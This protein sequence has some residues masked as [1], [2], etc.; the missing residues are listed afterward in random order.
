MTPNFVGCYYLKNS[1]HTSSF[2][3]QNLNFYDL[4]SFTGRPSTFLD[5]L[6]MKSESCANIFHIYF[7]YCKFIFKEK[8]FNEKRWGVWCISSWKWNITNWGIAMREL[9]LQKNFQTFVTN[10]LRW[11]LKNPSIS[12]SF[13]RN[14]KKFTS[15]NIKQARCFLKYF[16]KKSFCLW[17]HDWEFMNFC[18]RGV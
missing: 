7:F 13:Q 9:I 8:K 4:M 6:F 5:P 15:C 3:F 2:A 10:V 14:T 18:W 11:N 1:L 17:V 16:R 12:K